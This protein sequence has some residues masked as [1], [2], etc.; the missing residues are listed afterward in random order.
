MQSQ[1]I[2][3]R[4]GVSKAETAKIL[5]LLAWGSR[6]RENALP[7]TLSMIAAIRSS[8]TSVSATIREMSA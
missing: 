1:E 8:K 3:K 7:R 2:A 5:Q 4:I 6:T